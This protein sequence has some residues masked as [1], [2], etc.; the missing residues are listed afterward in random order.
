M[1]RR[2]W[3]STAVWF[4]GNAVLE[5]M[6]DIQPLRNRCVLITGG[7]RR[8]GAA[9]ARAMHGAGARV[10]IHCLHSR[11]EAEQLAMEF[12]SLRPD[13]ATV[14]TAD[15][16]QVPAIG[17]LVATVIERFGRLD[18][19]VNNASSFFPTPVG[20]I[21]LQDWED[22]IGTN[23]RGPLFVSQAAAPALRDARGSIIN[24]ADIHGQRPLK[25]H[26]VY[27]AA[28]AGLIMVTLSLAREL[29]PEVR[30]NAIAP[31]PV[32]WPEA[33]LPAALQDEI[34]AKTALKRAG[35][36]DD[37]AQMALFLAAGAPYV[38]GQV[39]AVDGGRTI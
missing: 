15:I 16:R 32:L 28:K 21:T 31:G 22:L 20:K 18:V 7:A 12:N 23:L 34:V 4:R 1:Q 3:Q 35:T 33:G 9:I 14:V 13:S 26:T 27:S 17:E 5:F 19:L 24:M 2:Q 38:T 29:G 10:A 30:V 37:I 6:T 39:I 36:P 25:R 8:L 11:D